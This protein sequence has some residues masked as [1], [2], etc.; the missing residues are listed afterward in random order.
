MF[1]SRV[2]RSEVNVI[3]FFALN[4]LGFGN[5]VGACQGWRAKSV[6]VF[7]SDVMISFE[8]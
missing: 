7:S 6:L 8:V 2:L 1:C 4:Y 3:E 5:R